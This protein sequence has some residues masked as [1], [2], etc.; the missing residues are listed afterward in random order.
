L[1]PPQQNYPATCR[2]NLPLSLFA[3]PLPVLQFPSR[4]AQDWCTVV[5]SSLLS[6][7]SSHYLP[8]T[9]WTSNGGLLLPNGLQLFIDRKGVGWNAPT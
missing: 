1:L 9:S 3:V 2:C 5:L 8:H 6:V 4:T 7:L